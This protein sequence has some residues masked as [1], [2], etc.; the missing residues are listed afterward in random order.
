MSIRG[1]R[2]QSSPSNQRALSPANPLATARTHRSLATPPATAR[3]PNE[4]LSHFIVYTH[5]FKGSDL[6]TVL[7]SLVFKT[8]VPVLRLMHVCVGVVSMVAGC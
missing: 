1:I 8:S 2:T 6:Q 4:V 5:I 3:T 7:G